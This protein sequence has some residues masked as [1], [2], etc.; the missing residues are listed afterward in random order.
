MT[1]CVIML[2]FGVVLEEPMEKQQVMHYL[3]YFYLFIYVAKRT[4]M[5]PCAIIIFF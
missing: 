5:A 2:L 1:L 4:R 3:L